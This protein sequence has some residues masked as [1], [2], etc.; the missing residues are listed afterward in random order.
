MSDGINPKVRPFHSVTAAFADGSDTP[1]DYLERC[2]EVIDAHEGTIGAFVATNLEGARAAADES[3][4]RWKDGNPL[5]QI[6]GMPVGVKDVMETADMVTEQG[7][8]LF[9]GWNMGRDCAAVAA[10]REAGAVVV[11]KTVTTEFA[12]TQPRGTRNPYDT[13]RTPGGS[14]SGSAAAVGCGMIAGATASQ[15]IGSTIRPASY[16]GAFGYK[17]T[18]GGI[19]RGGSFDDFSQSCTGAIAATLTD[20]W[21]MAREMS[22]R[23]GG[24][25]GYPGLM[26]PMDLPNADMP[27]TVAVLQT[28][29]WEAATDDAKQQL[30]K[31]RDVLSGAGIT[32][33]DRESSE[34]VEAVEQA[35]A[36]AN[37][38]S[39][40]INAWEGRW[41]LNT[42]SRDMDPSKLSESARERLDQANE[43]NQ[44]QY[45]ECIKRRDEVRAIHASLAEHCDVSATLAAPDAAPEGLGWTGDPNFTVF[46]SLLGVPALSIP[47]LETQG[48]PLGLQLI[49]YRDNDAAMFAGAAAILPLFGT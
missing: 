1:R 35:I 18:L 30:Q 49:G 16:C 3:T 9:V 21:R 2:I 10:L 43:M 4:A 11:G 28:A 13:D 26:G 17:P 36:D 25:P 15:V 7:S 47:V 39:R 41:P 6:D 37:P 42:Y 48:L 14:S 31:A 22:S 40:D 8:P 19:S 29:G 33:I 5:S 20:V 45:V 34:A 44:E 46:T 23:A 38:L 32:L 27:K 24:D 12:A